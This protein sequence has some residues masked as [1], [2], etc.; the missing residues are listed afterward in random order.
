M[1]AVAAECKRSKHHPK[2]TNIY[3]QVH[4]GWTTHSPRG[5]SEKDIAMARICDEKAKDFGEIKSKVNSDVR[6][7]RLGSE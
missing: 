5:L 1:D 4:I 7:E 6:T 3:N 2:W